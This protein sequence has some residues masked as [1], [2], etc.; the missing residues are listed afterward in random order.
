MG[1]RGAAQSAVS[2][3][4]SDE[5]NARLELVKVKEEVRIANGS[6]KSLKIMYRSL[7]S[8]HLDC[9][10]DTKRKSSQALDSSLSIDSPASSPRKVKVFP[11][12]R[13]VKPMP[14]RA[15]LQ[16]TTTQNPPA[17]TTTPR[18]A[19]P[20]V[21]FR[22]S[23]SSFSPSSPS[24]ASAPASTV[25]TARRTR[26]AR[27]TTSSSS[28]SDESDGHSDV[29]DPVPHYRTHSRITYPHAIEHT[30]PPTPLLM[31]IVRQR[32]IASRT[33]STTPS[34]KLA[35]TKTKYVRSRRNTC[36]IVTPPS[37]IVSLVG[38]QEDILTQ[39]TTSEHDLVICVLIWIIVLK[40][41]SLSSATKTGVCP[42][43]SFGVR[44]PVL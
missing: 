5:R 23:V 1:L 35:R 20:E 33:T 39:S 15:R 37:P 40:T 31:R 44:G 2:R 25:T 11:Y 22:R 12:G 28:D 19:D 32:P 42:L 4:T 24:S 29:D 26:V 9:P 7:G 21:V 16:P 27:Y 14:K 3:L 34:R 43:Y 17:L 38:E 10:P 6:F 36:T 41:F 18:F 13:P 30:S 8:I